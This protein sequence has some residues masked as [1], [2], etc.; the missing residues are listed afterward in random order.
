MYPEAAALVKIKGY[1]SGAPSGSQAALFYASWPCVPYSKADP[2][3]RGTGDK[4]FQND[5]KE[6]IESIETLDP[7]IVLV[8]CAPGILEKLGGKYSAVE[9]IQNSLP[10]FFCETAVFETAE[11]VSPITGKQSPSCKQSALL[12]LHNMSAFSHKPTMGILGDKTTPLS[13]FVNFLDTK[14]IF[15]KNFNQM[16]LQ[17]QI[18]LEIKF[19]QEKSTPA[20][21]AAIRDAQPGIGEGGFK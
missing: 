11:L 15:F 18:D 7:A 2:H 14:G 19:S 17:D 6:M 10:E 3:R 9:N 5:L 4:L 20:Y 1:K 21:V 8:E 13:S 12:V 16:P